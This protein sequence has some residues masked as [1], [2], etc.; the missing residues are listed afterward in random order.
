MW[1]R[2]ELQYFEFSENFSQVELTEIKFK[3]R[4]YE[5]ELEFIKKVIFIACVC[6]Y[7]CTQTYMCIQ[8]CH[9]GSVEVIKQLA[10]VSLK[11]IGFQ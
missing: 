11:S 2:E 10:R 3:M 5:A 6:W 7:V 1:P 9:D 4:Q 8:T